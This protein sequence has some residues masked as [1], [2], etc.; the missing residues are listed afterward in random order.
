MR[1]KVIILT[2]AN[3]NTG[4]VFEIYLRMTA[5]IK[6]VGFSDKTVYR[7]PKE[8]YMKNSSGDSIEYNF[9]KDETE[10]AEYQEDSTDFALLEVP[11]GSSLADEGSM[12]KSYKMLI[13]AKNNSASS[14]VTLE[15][16]NYQP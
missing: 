16:I 3:L 8:I 6:N 2:T 5:T 14:G 11:N 12:P 13:K 1:N 4:S 9:I 15:L 10:W 7:Y